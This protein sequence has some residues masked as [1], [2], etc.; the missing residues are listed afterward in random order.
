[1]VTN[2]PIRNGTIVEVGSEANSMGK[3]SQRRQ[4]AILPL[5]ITMT[6]DG[7]T[8]LA[9]S[10][11]ISASGVRVISSTPLAVGT[12]ISVEYKHRRALGTVQWCRSLRDRK[13]EHEIGLLLTN[14]G[15]AFWGVHMK[16]REVD[17]EQDEL[18]AIPYD[19]VAQLLNQKR[20]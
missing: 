2:L 12:A 6:A 17:R 14:A 16:L 3:R 13:F 5:K 1:V 8:Q 10:V 9:H 18:E 19:Q 7:K 20:T 15:T 4:K 11:D